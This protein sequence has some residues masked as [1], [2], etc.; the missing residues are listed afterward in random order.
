MPTVL[1]ISL[2]TGRPMAMFGLFLMFSA[3]FVSESSR[4]AVGWFLVCGGL[5]LAWVGKIGLFFIR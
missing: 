2:V 3:P 5:T 1:K 4:L